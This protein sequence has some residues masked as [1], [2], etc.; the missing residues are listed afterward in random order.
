[1]KKV[2]ALVLALLA[3]LA[4]VF[5]A[6]ADVPD[7]PKEFAYAYDYA[8]GVLSANDMNT[9]A[10]YGKALED[11]TG[12]QAI[13]V[14]VNFL[15]GMTPEDYATD[16]IN[17]WG[18]GS[19]DDDDGVVVLLAI[20]DRKIQIGTGSGLDR[21]LTGS[22]SGALIDDNFDYFA[23][24]DY[25]DGVRNL[26]IDVC[27]YVAKAQGK[28]LAP[29]SN[30]SNVVYGNEI[31]L[32][33][34]NRVITVKTKKSGGLFDGL[35]GLVFLYIVASVVINAISPK[36]CCSGGCLK[37]LFMGW[38]FDLFKGNGNRRPPSGGGFGGGPRMPPR[39]PR[40][41][42][43]GGGSFWGGG[44]GG[45]SFGGGSR[46]GFGGGSS[47]GGGGGRSF[48][49]GS[50]GGGSFGGGSRGSFGGGS[51]GGGFGGGSSRG[52]GGGRSF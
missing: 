52:G 22:R 47:R 30:A 49:G 7:K 19:A 39:P 37:F 26:Y 5:G 25:A 45:G 8:G 6:A 3:A 34:Q 21:V 10:E 32:G 2:L 29:T 42:G 41:G 13:A 23:D 15:D 17:K 35:L 18:V 20:G 44:F 36:G 4:L 33:G 46:G 50:F 16:I 43:F 31:N 14:V 48:G 1:M 38:L 24:G 51:R 40:T 9:I 12:A 28:T 11:A 27:E